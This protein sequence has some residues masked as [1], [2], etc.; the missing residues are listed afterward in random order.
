MLNSGVVIEIARCSLMVVRRA[1][2]KAGR[3]ECRIAHSTQSGVDL[4]Y[5]GEAAAIS[6]AL[7]AESGEDWV[8]FQ[9]TQAC[10]TGVQE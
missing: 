8:R 1:F 2:P 10:S 3:V 6:W 9:P 4:G 7:R 5:F